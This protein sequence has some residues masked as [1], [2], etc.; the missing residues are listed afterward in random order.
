MTIHFKTLIEI[1]DRDKIRNVIA[2]LVLRPEKI[3]YLFRKKKHWEAVKDDLDYF[4]KQ[5]RIP[6]TITSIVIDSDETAVIEEALDE[7][8][9]QE[10]DIAFEITGGNDLLLAKIYH[11]CRRHG[12]PCIHKA[13]GEN[14][15]IVEKGDGAA[16]VSLAN[17]QLTI[18]ELIAAYGAEVMEN[19]HAAPDFEDES[20]LATVKTIA[21]LALARGGAWNRFTT[22]FGE[23][24]PRDSKRGEALRLT[25]PREKKRGNTRIKIDPQ[26]IHTLAQT[27]LIW[28]VTEQERTVSL[29]TLKD[30]RFELMRIQGLY[31]EWLT[32]LAARRT[33]AFDDVMMSA[34]INWLPGSE[35]VVNNEI[36]G[37]LL[38]GT[39]PVFISCKTSMVNTS[40]YILNEIKTLCEQFG[41]GRARSVLVCSEDVI[42]PMPNIS[43]RAR[44]M[45]VTI[46]DRPMIPKLGEHLKALL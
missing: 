8:V 30:Q 45:G 21:D 42:K 3:I 32:Y 28:D 37:I 38:A 24:V 7:I 18:P 25:L 9:A 35:I 19:G 23:S 10:T 5:R 41:G 4:F 1:Y 11:Y 34:V 6:L 13:F 44:K 43:L 16:A 2:P 14:K 40:V 20:L 27:G 39:T 46:I 36:D 26:V 29:T 12:H 33:E 15:L 17:V 22:I 31:L